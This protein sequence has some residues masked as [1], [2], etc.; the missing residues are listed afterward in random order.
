M[1]KKVKHFVYYLVFFV[2]T[3]FLNLD[4]FFFHSENSRTFL[5]EILPIYFKTT[6]IAGSWGKRRI[7]G[8][9][10]CGSSWHAGCCRPSQVKSVAATAVSGREPGLTAGDWETRR[11]EAATETAGESSCIFSRNF[12]Q[13]SCPGYCDVHRVFE[14]ESY[15]LQSVRFLLLVLL[16]AM[17]LFVGNCRVFCYSP[18]CCKRD[19]RDYP[20]SSTPCLR[21]AWNDWRSTRVTAHSEVWEEPNNAIFF[22]NV[23][24]RACFD[25]VLRELIPWSATLRLTV[26]LTC[27]T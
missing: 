19:N 27:F 14:N 25:V 9:T 1:M 12:T 3:D 21:A 8:S 7:S 5:T 18:N 15:S 2:D 11:R 17:H 10:R 20:K 26:G 24:K 22:L 23:K 13:C 6:F 4:S 16:F